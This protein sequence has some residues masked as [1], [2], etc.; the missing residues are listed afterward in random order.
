MPAFGNT[1]NYTE[2]KK[3]KSSD[4][5]LNRALS[6][7]KLNDYNGA[8]EDANSAIQIKPNNSKAYYIRGLCKSKLNQ[9][10]S[11]QPTRNIKITS[12]SKPDADFELYIKEIQEKIKTNWYPP[13]DN[14]SK[15]V[16]LQFKILKDGTINSIKVLK[17]SNFY[18]M[19]LAAQRAIKISAPFP[20]LPSTFKEESIDVE[21]L[22]DYNIVEKNNSRRFKP[23]FVQ[24]LD[25]FNGIRDFINEGI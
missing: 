21:F 12:I 3:L 11:N 9:A 17:S 19:D 1:S 4:A 13:K 18:A 10:A 6:K 7:Y 22:F 5:Y 23:F 15:D 20:Q 16:I 2:E 8:I 24:P 14:E 25:I